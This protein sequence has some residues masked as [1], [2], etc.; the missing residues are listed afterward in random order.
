MFRGGV[1]LDDAFF[2]FNPFGA[3]DLAR[4]LRARRKEKLDRVREDLFP[5][6]PS[7]LIGP[8]R[9]ADGGLLNRDLIQQKLQFVLFHRSWSV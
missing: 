9:V 3:A 2:Q 8:R 4:L 7:A 5:L 1:G 6:V